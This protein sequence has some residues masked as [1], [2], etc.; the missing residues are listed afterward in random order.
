MGISDHISWI[1]I[2]VLLLIILKKILDNNNLKSSILLLIL[3]TAH[4]YELKQGKIIILITS[5]YDKNETQTIKLFLSNSEGNERKVL[6]FGPEWKI[7]LLKKKLLNIPIYPIRNY[8]LLDRMLKIQKKPT[9]IT[10]NRSG[11][12]SKIEYI[13]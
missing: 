3:T 8:E 1:T 6:F 9:I 2:I 11:I 5:I 4:D 7:N 12:I 10:L 13:D